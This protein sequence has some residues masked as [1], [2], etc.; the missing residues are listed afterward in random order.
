MRKDS[1]PVS[2]LVVDFMATQDG[3]KQR[4]NETRSNDHGFVGHQDPMLSRLEY[5]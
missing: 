2:L 1:L 5:R 4:V 3:S